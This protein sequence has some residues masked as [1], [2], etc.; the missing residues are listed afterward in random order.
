MTSVIIG[1]AII[2]SFLSSA[3]SRVPITNL[4]D[5]YDLQVNPYDEDKIRAQQVVHYFEARFRVALQEIMR[6][7]DDDQEWMYRFLFRE[8]VFLFYCTMPNVH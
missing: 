1:S 2:L 3:M 5:A 7:S 6:R 4:F 8:L